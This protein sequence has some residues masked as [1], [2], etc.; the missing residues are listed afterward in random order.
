MKQLNGNYTIVGTIVFIVVVFVWIMIYINDKSTIWYDS[1]DENK[2]NHAYGIK[3]FK[4]L[5]K[6]NLAEEDRFFTINKPLRTFLG[7]EKNATYMYVGNSF[8]YF[9][10]KDKN[11]FLKFISSGNNAFIATNAFP[12]E[13]LEDI[14]HAKYYTII[15]DSTKNITTQ[16]IPDSSTNEI[17]EQGQEEVEVVEEEAEVIEEE[18]STNNDSIINF[19]NV[20]TS[21]RKS[22][23]SIYANNG[24]KL[25]YNKVDNYKPDSIFDVSE[26]S[27]SL[28][29]WTASKFE[30]LAKNENNKAVYIKIP[31]GKGA[32]YLW[33]NPFV[34]G[35]INMIDSHGPELFSFIFKDFKKQTV[36]WEK[37]HLQRN[38]KGENQQRFN[39]SLSYI[40][41]QRELK[42]GWYI[43][44]ATGLLYLIFNIK[45]RQKS[46]PVFQLPENTTEEY[47][48]TISR[49]YQSENDN[50]LGILR[51]K[52]DHLFVFIRQ[53]FK[54]TLREDKEEFIH[55]LHL[56]SGIDKTL[57]E[58]LI[59]YHGLLNNIDMLD[60]KY[61][62]EIIEV[63]NKFY[64]HT[65]N[66]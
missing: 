42:W 9:T 44:L 64:A 30:I 23:L 21:D 52:L 37:F 35:N 17:N 2:T 33:V 24:F 59:T 28:P 54:I 6:E 32:I 49:L 15:N 53:K 43:L 4:D 60:K 13:L 50:H 55:R 39:N 5:V 26:I 47:L 18:S 11:A 25:R 22:Y 34:L 65:S 16:A 1:L 61:H 8:L 12:D 66:Q 46:I 57:I 40:L 62:K 41:S 63:I 51:M 38:D 45:K 14:I 10:S 58:S 31:Y 19:H 27:D 20:I 7:D 3:L 56:V 29:L 48:E 36:Y